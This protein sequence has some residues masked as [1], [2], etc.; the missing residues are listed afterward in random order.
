MDYPDLLHTLI[1]AG[2]VKYSL[3]DDDSNTIFLLRDGQV[4]LGV[5]RYKHY[6]ESESWMV[7]QMNTVNES[8]HTILNVL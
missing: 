8:S 7:N 6:A 3:G 1:E 5:A 4:K 2:R